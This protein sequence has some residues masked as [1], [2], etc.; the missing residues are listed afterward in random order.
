MTFYV[1]LK[2]QPDD[3]E[4]YRWFQ[5]FAAADDEF[6]CAIAHVSKKETTGQYAGITAVTKGRCDPD[7]GNIR[8]VE[9][10]VN[11]E[12]NLVKR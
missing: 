9:V 10:Y 4:L 7:Y 8:H 1:C 11:A 2:K 6:L 3:V 12:G 5:T